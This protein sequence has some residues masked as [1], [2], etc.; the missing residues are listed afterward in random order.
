MTADG[1]L[2][3]NSQHCLHAAFPGPREVPWQQFS[4]PYWYQKGCQEG[5]HGPNVREMA[6]K[7]ITCAPDRLQQLPV[8]GANWYPGLKSSCPQP[9]ASELRSQ[10]H[11]KN[12]DISPTGTSVRQGQH[13]EN[14]LA[15]LAVQLQTL[16]MHLPPRTEA[17]DHLLN[18]TQGL[19]NWSSN[20]NHLC[21]EFLQSDYSAVKSHVISL[22]FHFTDYINHSHF[23]SHHFI[24]PAHQQMTAKPSLFILHQEQKNSSDLGSSASITGPITRVISRYWRF[25]SPRANPGCALG[26]Q[27]QNCAMK[28]LITVGGEVGGRSFS[29]AT[30]WL[31]SCSHSGQY[32]WSWT[33]A[34]NLPPRC[35]SQRSQRDSTLLSLA[36]REHLL[37]AQY[38]IPNF[39]SQVLFPEGW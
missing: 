11:R 20:V 27:K 18:Q 28:E 25:S 6:Q 30:T 2:R 36:K 10:G 26:H 22:L 9:T 29:T 13:K 34:S 24:N 16:R 8:W 15:N 7:M 12:V 38:C 33:V 39:F 17:E 21:K 35:P 23:R 19:K 5:F 3:K 4:Q 37:S 14:W 32:L 31:V 1:R